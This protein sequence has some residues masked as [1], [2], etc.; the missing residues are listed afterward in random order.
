LLLAAT[1]GCGG[2]PSEENGEPY[3]NLHGSSDRAPNSTLQDWVSYA[4]EVVVA[5]VTAE[6]ELPASADPAANAGYFGRVAS[7]HVER[8]LWHRRGAPSAPSTFDLVV[9]GW[10]GPDRRPVAAD[11]VRVEVGR[12]YLIPM[13]RFA[14]NGTVVGSWAPLSASAFVP[15]TGSAVAPVGDAHRA[16]TPLT[17]DTP[18]QISAELARTTPDPLAEKHASLDP[19]ARVQAVLKE[20]AGG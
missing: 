15:W 16:V 14:E 6:K 4:D 11:G 8:R 17:G 10:G 19:A 7:F 1:A 13:A 2:S 3:I 9:T 18:E 20:R 5:N 12:S